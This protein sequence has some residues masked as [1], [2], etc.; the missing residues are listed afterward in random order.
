M[1]D[2]RDFE[3][4]IDD[5]E[6]ARLGEISERLHRERPVPGAAFRGALRTQLFHRRRAFGGEKWVSGGRWR[7]L[8]ATYSCLGALLLAVAAVGLAG[9]GPFGP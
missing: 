8:A 6:R 2:D 3:A 7:A 5:S 1:I 4:G 9:A